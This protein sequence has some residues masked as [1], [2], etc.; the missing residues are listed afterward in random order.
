MAADSDSKKALW[1]EKKRVQS[2][3]L[4]TETNKAVPKEKQMVAS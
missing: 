1:T 3:V 2:S 4:R